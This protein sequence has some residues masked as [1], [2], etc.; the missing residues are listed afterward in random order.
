MADGAHARGLRLR[1]ET[2]ELRLVVVEL[3]A[4][5]ERLVDGDLRE[6]ESMLDARR[7]RAQLDESAFETAERVVRG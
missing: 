6:R 2:C 7:L 1:R 3:C 4:C 5:E